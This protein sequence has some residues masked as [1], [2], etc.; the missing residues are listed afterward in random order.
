MRRISLLGHLVPLMQQPEP[1]ATQAL[2]YV[3]EA[4]PDIVDEFVFLLTGER[5]E[6]GRIA[7]EWQFENK[8]QP[9]VVIFDGHGEVRLFVENKF[10]APLTRKQPVAYLLALPDG[11]QSVLAF[12]APKDRVFGLWNELKELC[13]AEKLD[14]ADEI[15]RDEYRR[16]RVGERTLLL[17]NW[18][19][20]LGSL[21]RVAAAGG[22][23][24]IVH[25]ID[26]LRGL[27]E[28]M[29]SGV[30]MPLR[31]DE[32]TDQRTPKRLLNYASLIDD[33]VKGLVED[34]VADTSRL[35]A[36]GWGRYLK[37]Q[38]RCV[39]SLRISLTAWRRFGITPLWC[40]ILSGYEV[41]PGLLKGRF[42]G[43]R[44]DD[45][46]G[47]LVPIRVSTGV[48]RDQVVSDAVVQMRDLARLLESA[49]KS[50]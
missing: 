26:Q 43:A 47:L 4:A 49:S 37:L 28:R 17:T 18:R 11:R 32:P 10:W 9:D 41:S 46:G 29:N 22:H 12:I 16:I 6:V 20:V 44:E 50:P 27:T 5:F 3:L 19:F 7:S 24:T 36:T 23:E 8:V 13:G 25:D 38:K 35:T 45:K 31:G 39:V 42:D 30:F 40:K 33:I 48:E 21:R 2:A 14:L 34:G 15:I 1:A